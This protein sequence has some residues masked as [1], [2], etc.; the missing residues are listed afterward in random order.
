MG[1]LRL[2]VALSDM[3]KTQVEQNEL[4]ILPVELE[5]ICAL[6]DLPH[7]HK[8]PFDRL[9]ISQAEI[10]S[11][12]LVTVDKKIGLYDVETLGVPKQR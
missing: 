6:T 8:G 12:I 3:M 11:M 5:H 4:Q 2:H 10:E 7:H 1:K 9:L